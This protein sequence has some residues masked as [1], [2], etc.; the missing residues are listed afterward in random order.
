MAE[1]LDMGLSNASHS[2][3]PTEENPS[4]APTSS[5]TDTEEETQ[6]SAPF[7]V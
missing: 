6:D 1:P 7:R 5:H 2:A 4:A 3:G